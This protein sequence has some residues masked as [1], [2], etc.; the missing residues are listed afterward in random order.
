MRDL[1]LA[2]SRQQTVRS[3]AE[4]GT[5]NAASVLANDSDPDGD[6]LAI[7]AT[8]VPNDAS[9]PSMYGLDKIDAPEGW[10]TAYGPTG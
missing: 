5:L 3:V 6:P 8:G 9:F 4:N 2:P 1:P 7:T 10:T